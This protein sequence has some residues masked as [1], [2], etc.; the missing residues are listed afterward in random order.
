[1]KTTDN[2]SRLRKMVAFERCMVRAQKGSPDSWLLKG[3]FA[4]QLRFRS[5]ARTTRDIDLSA[6]LASGN[7]DQINEET[8][9]ARLSESISGDLKDFFAYVVGSSVEVPTRI[10]AVRAYRYPVRASLDNRLFEQ[11][12]IDVGVGDPLVLPAVDLPSSGLLDFAEL[13]SITFRAIS[14]EQHFAEKIHAL[15]RTYEGGESSRTRDL[16]DLILLLDFG[17]AATRTIRTAILKIFEARKTHAV[18][19]DLGDPPSSWKR[20][21]EELARALSLSQKTIDEA[22]VRLR[23][24]WKGLAWQKG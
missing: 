6:N 1:M 19:A 14:A 18:P 3:G 17:L 21:Y 23:S 24:Y 22:M 2:L 11:F 5:K 9:G 16:V 15:T 4:L 20:E 7:A 10:G 12:H 8:I 13:P